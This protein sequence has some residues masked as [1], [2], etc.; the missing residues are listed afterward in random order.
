MAVR[1]PLEDFAGL[2]QKITLTIYQN[3]ERHITGPILQELLIDMCDTFAA[4][5]AAAITEPAQ[6]YYVNEIL[7]NAVAKTITLVRAGGIAPAN[8]SASLA[9]LDPERKGVVNV[10][11]GVNIITFAP[12]RLNADPYGLDFSVINGA[13]F[14][15]GGEESELGQYTFKMTVDEDGVLTYETIP[16]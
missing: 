12:P 2:I 14:D 15:I 7:I 3:H 11:A 16:E 6:N 10:V 5:V 8:I 1:L 4:Y 9:P 13:G